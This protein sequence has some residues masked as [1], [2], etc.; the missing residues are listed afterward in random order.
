MVDEAHATGVLGEHGRG[1]CEWLGVED[2]VPVRVGTLSKALGSIGGFVTGSAELIDWLI[3]R[4][5]PY[6]F[7]MRLEAH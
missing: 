3:S 6:V 7:S 1:A 5:R 4:A 2:Q